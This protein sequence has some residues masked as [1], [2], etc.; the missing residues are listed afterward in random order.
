VSYSIRRLTRDDVAAY[1]AI[2]LEALTHHPEAFASSAEEFEQRTDDQLRQTL[3]G[4]TIYA[5]ILPDGSLGGMNAFLRA[6]GVKDSHRGWMLQV[7]V[8]PQYRGTG[9][10]KALAEH[11]IA[12]VPEGVKQIHLGVWSENDPAIGLYERLGFVTYGT[13]PRY[14][15]VNGRYIDEHMMVRFLDEAPGKTTENE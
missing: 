5:A 10:A 14:L 9:M 6:N 13:E 7:Y 4:L 12:Q 8:R 15:Y 2:R 11:L 1:R 3:E